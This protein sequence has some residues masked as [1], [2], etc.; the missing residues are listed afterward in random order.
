LTGKPEYYFIPF[1][2]AFLIILNLYLFLNNFAI[3]FIDF[4]IIIIDLVLI[5]GIVYYFIKRKS[6]Q[7]E[8]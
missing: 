3:D 2:I 4:F 7:K 1:I 6:K 5:F 8:T